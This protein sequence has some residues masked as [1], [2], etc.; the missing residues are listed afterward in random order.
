MA[1]ESGEYDIP[2]KDAVERHFPEFM[3]F[4]FP[5]AC[6]RVVSGTYRSK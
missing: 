1:Q 5:D 2:W 4:F 6:R 3:E